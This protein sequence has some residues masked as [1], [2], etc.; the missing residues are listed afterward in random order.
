MNQ[1]YPKRPDYQLLEQND[2]LFCT[3]YFILVATL[4]YAYG[5]SVTPYSESLTIVQHL[6][7]RFMGSI[8]C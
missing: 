7:E 5:D 3:V 4:M 1:N 6:T 8:V 2:R